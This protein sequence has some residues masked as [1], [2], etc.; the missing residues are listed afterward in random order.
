[1]SDEEMSPTEN[2]V[3][4]ETSDDMNIEEDVVIIEDPALLAEDKK[5]QGNK[6]YKQQK[7]KDAVHC[8]T[9]AINLCPKCAAYY[10]NRAA[11]YMMLYK[12]KEALEDAQQSVQYDNK[13]LKGY[14]REGKC[15]LVLGNASAAIRSYQ[16][17]LQLDPKNA[18][19]QN[20]IKTS[21]QILDLTEKAEICYGRQDFRTTIYYMDKCL[22]HCSGCQRFK[23]LK[24]ESLAL[25]GRYDESEE[26]ANNILLCDNMCA[27]A[28]YVRGLCLY[29]RDNLPKAFQHFQKVLRLAP[30]HQRARLAYK[31]AKQLT[32]KKEEGNDAFR[33]GKYQ[34]AHDLYSEALSIDPFN[35]STNSKLF[36]NRATVSAKLKKYEESVEDCTKA[37]ELDESY[38]K[39]FSRRARSYMEL[40]RFEDA[41]RD[42][43]KIF[44]L[45]KTREN[46][47][48]L[49]DAKLEL[50]KSKRKD[51]YKLLGVQKGATE[52]EIKKA[53]KKRALIH[54][55]DRH[56]H[57]EEKVQK[58]EEVK[59][60]EVG[61]AYG[62]LSDSK[63][64]MR[65]DAG[66]DLEDLDGGGGGFHQMDPNQ[67]FQMMFGGGGMNGFHYSSGGAQHHGHGF[68]FQFG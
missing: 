14:L 52:E 65:Y 22:V 50:K 2:S 7:Y 11:A 17:V 6:F 24:A 29:Y 46:K 55:P 68:N 28:T 47:K 27:D 67:I 42:Y 21:E 41:V 59:F 25:L 12:Y 18:T 36:C 63:K 37:I 31:K 32:S 58:E 4:E 23:I 8:Y 13:F 57:A 54:H 53:Y 30:D 16:H 35:K 60:K 20:E 19:S 15:H 26:L 49:N 66:Q 33:S 51:Y 44:S 5:E 64:R 62:V 48:I 45:E 43:E 56:S 10:S 39:A 38:V 3:S 1:M 34:D 40:E 9:E 61:E